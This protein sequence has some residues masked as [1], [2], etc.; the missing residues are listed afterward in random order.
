MN[1]EQFFCA[2]KDII[3]FTKPVALAGHA[4]NLKN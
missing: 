1:T 2:N 3:L 4:G